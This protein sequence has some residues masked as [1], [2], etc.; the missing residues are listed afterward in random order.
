MLSNQ[1]CKPCEGKTLALSK[2]EIT[3]L[4]KELNEWQ[5]KENKKI[6]KNF[7][8]KNFNK[9][10]AFVNEVGKIAEKEGHHPDIFL[11]SWN[12]V[13]ITTYTHSIGGLSKN[14]FIIASKIDKL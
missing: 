1:K 7:I 14:D 10:L 12:H 9:A 6:E 11:Y 4:I 5:N 13:L 3:P 8:F 2:K